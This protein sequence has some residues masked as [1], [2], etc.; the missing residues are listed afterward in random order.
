[1]FHELLSRGSAGVV[2]YLRCADFIFFDFFNFD[3]ATRGISLNLNLL[4]ST[5]WTFQAQIMGRTYERSDYRARL[6]RG[7]PGFLA[8]MSSSQVPCVYF[9]GIWLPVDNNM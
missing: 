4:L 3:F 2:W 7:K 5:V 6:C 8:Q 9:S 1:M